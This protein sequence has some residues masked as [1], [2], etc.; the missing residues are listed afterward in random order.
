MAGEGRLRRAVPVGAIW[1]L[2]PGY[3]QTAMVEPIGKA[4]RQ[5]GD[6]LGSAVVQSARHA[7][8]AFQALIVW[9]YASGGGGGNTVI[10]TEAGGSVEPPERGRGRLVVVMVDW[11]VVGSRLRGGCKLLVSTKDCSTIV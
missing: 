7:R 1:Q 2:V 5:P 6:R 11:Q 10:V 9:T 3:R 8:C 4:S